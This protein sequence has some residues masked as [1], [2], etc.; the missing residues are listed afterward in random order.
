MV[1]NLYCLPAVCLVPTFAIV[2]YRTGA[3]SATARNSAVGRNLQDHPKNPDV[4]NFYSSFNRSSNSIT[5]FISTLEYGEAIKNEI[6]QRNKNAQI[7]VLNPK[8]RGKIELRG[9]SIFDKPFI[10]QYY[11]QHETDM[12]TMLRAIEQFVAVTDTE[13]Y[14]RNEAKFIRFP[15]PAGD[16]LPYQ[17]DEFYRFYI[18]QL[19]ASSYHPVYTSKMGPASDPDAVVDHR[20]RVKGIQNFRQ[21]DARRSKCKYESSDNYGC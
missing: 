2:W 6:L 4:G 16:S 9:R 11:L 19:G 10:Y 7:I 18:R 20:L 1:G 15:L 12:E 13:I 3:T 5:D 14:R 21:I 17:S 8:S